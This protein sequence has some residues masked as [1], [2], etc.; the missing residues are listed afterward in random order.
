M[1]KKIT[2]IS[3]VIAVFIQL[4]LVGYAVYS[5]YSNWDNADKFSTWVLPSIAVI[6]ALILF[7][8]Y[9][10]LQPNEAAVISF[11]GKYKGSLNTNG[12]LFINPFYGSNTWSLKVSNYAMEPLK[13]NEKNGVPIEIAAIIVWKV[14]DTYKAQYDVEDLDEY[15]DN[16]F[17]ISLRTLAKNHTYSELATEEKDFIAD[18]TD[19]VSKAGVIILDAKI[20]HLNYVPEIAAAMLQK[21][22]ASAMSEA[23]E[24]IVDNAVN[25]ATAAAKEITEMSSEQKGIFISNLIIVLCSERAVSPVVTV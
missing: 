25:I 9:V 15:I 19:K 23:K 17:E 16:Q 5:I 4:L 22:Q 21:Q 20:T 14:G 1:E 7:G 24:I 12:F 6:I 18:L 2:V 10:V 8:G 13:V 11:M 3:G